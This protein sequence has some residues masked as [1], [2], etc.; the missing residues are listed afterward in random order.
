MVTEGEVI[1][2]IHRTPGATDF[3]GIKRRVRAGQGRCQAGFCGT[4][5][6]QILSREL[7]IPLDKVTKKGEGSELLGPS[8]KS[9]RS[10][11]EPAR[12]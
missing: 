5:I 6:P 3:D 4:Q 10:G 8:T 2:A 7:K 9:L 11:N 1:E 12:C